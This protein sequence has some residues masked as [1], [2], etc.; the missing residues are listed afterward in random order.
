MI[1]VGIGRNPAGMPVMLEK[2]C[3][4]SEQLFYEDG[5]SMAEEARQDGVLVMLDCIDGA[6]HEPRRRYSHSSGD[7]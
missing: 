7:L 5:P 4:T 6:E 1:S 3:P 2:A